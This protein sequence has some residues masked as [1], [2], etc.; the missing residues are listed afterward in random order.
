V[1]YNLQR[2]TIN[3]RLIPGSSARHIRRGPTYGRASRAATAS[4]IG[5][6]LFA[7]SQWAILIL[8]ARLGS[9][10][11]VGHYAL[12]LAIC[13]PL[14]LWLGSNHRTVLGSD[15]LE[16]RSFGVYLQGR[17]FAVTLAAALAIGAALFLDIPTPVFGVIL[18]VI[19]LKITDQLF[20]I[21]YGWHQRKIRMD[22]VALSLIMRGTIAVVI[23]GLSL[24]LTTNLHLALFGVAGSWA[25]ILLFRELPLI[26]QDGGVLLHRFSEMRTTAQLFRSTWPLAVVALLASLF[27]N[28]PR[29]FIESMLGPEALGIYAALAYLLV[30]GN[31]VSH[32][33]C[34]AVSPRLAHAF[35][36]HDHSEVMKLSMLMLGAALL[37]GL[38][39]VGAAL[40]AGDQ[41]LLVLYGGPF[42][43]HGAVLFVLT[44]GGTFLFVSSAAW[45]GLTSMSKY[46]W[47]ISGYLGSCVLAAVVTPPLVGRYGLIGGAT[48]FA[49]GAG[50]LAFVFVGL[51]AHTLTLS[52]HRERL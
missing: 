23:V 34:A 22:R 25:V 11:L 10:E 33:V 42:V 30:A 13:S 27:P 50:F 15:S 41:I 38:A 9:V 19:C 8:I 47:Q 7:A 48:G 46:G 49:V 14:F 43:G 3:Y 17:V 36:S 26:A 32:A 12:G 52:V 37:L 39:L 18:G 51:L 45:Y 44:I 40:I 2:S 28:L 4:I 6:V 20:D 5:N 1:L 24:H 21:T 29:Y 16:T 35:S 31:T